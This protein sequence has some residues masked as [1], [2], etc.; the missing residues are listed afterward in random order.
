[1]LTFAP[2]TETHAANEVAQFVTHGFDGTQIIRMQILGVVAGKDVVAQD[3]SVEDD[4]IH[5]AV[6]GC[7]CA[8]NNFFI[9]S[10]GEG[11]SH[12]IA[13]H[14]AETFVVSVVIHGG[15]NAVATDADRFV[16]DVVI[17]RFIAT[18]DHV[19][20][21]VV[22]VG[23]STSGCDS[24]HAGVVGAVGQGTNIVIDGAGAHLADAGFEVA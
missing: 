12:F 9:H 18:F 19:A 15:G 2:V 24:M 3:F 6:L 17:N 5:I 20:V 14:F 23:F 10:T 4:S 7:L 8:F 1:M 13:I 21:L 22:L 16:K 11:V